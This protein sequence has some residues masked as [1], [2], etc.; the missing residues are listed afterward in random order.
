[1]NVKAVGRWL[2]E[3]TT[4]FPSNDELIAIESQPL[5]GLADYIVRKHHTFTRNEM[6][7]LM[8]LFK[9]VCSKHGT[10]HS[11][12]FELQ[13]EFKTL[14]SELGTHMIKEENVLFPYIS[15][16]ETAVSENS[17]Q[18]FSPFAAVQNPIAVMMRE[19]D[20]AGE[21]LKR[22]RVLSNDFT[23]PAEACISYQTLYEAL[24]ELEADLHQH[25]HLENNV[26]FPRV[27]EMENALNPALV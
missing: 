4:S 13:A 22:M 20:A 17:P 27:L 8:L 5:S 16:L 10:D 14:Y 11:E 7:R 1:L 9:K 12:L 2:G 26:L 25:I 3:L 19:H 15:Q 23:V 24:T 18:P 6:L 21:I